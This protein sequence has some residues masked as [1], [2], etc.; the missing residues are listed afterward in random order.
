MAAT[1]IEGY[2]EA[3]EYPYTSPAY[4][5][6]PNHGYTVYELT[7][8][9]QAHDVP[10][11]IGVTAD[12][13]QYWTNKPG[14][15]GEETPTLVASPD[16]TEVVEGDYEGIQGPEQYNAS[17]AISSSGNMVVSY[18]NQ[19]LLS[20]GPATK[21]PWTPTETTPIRT[22]TSSGCRNRRTLPVR[23]SWAGPTATASI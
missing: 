2:D 13:A 10:I 6:P 16:V 4:L 7:F 20:G 9:G 18:T 11:E 22:S 14:A 19:P 15:N 5:T 17:A 23:G 1:G 3:E 21:S 8:Q 12:Q